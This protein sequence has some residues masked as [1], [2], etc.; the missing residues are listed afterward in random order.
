MNIEKII[1]Q[2]TFDEK[3]MLLT[4]GEG[5]MLTEACERLG[6]KP[7]KLA[8]GPHGI[9]AEKEKNCTHFP[10][11]CS[12]AA[13]WSKEA[14]NKMGDALGAECIKNGI[15]MLLGPG[16]NIKRTPLC[17]RNFEYLSEDPVLAGELGAEYIKGL[18]S[19]NVA[20]CPKHYALNNQE[21]YRQTINVEAD[22][23]TMREIYLK[24]FEIAVKKGKPE[25]IMSAYNKVN[26]IWCS[27]NK[28]LLKS[29][30]RDEWNYDGLVISD[31]GSVHDASRSAAAGCDMQMGRNAKIAEQLKNGVE[32]GLVTIEEIDEAVRNTLKFLTRERESAVEYD[33]E[34]Q[35]RIA[36][37]IA[38]EG[39]VLLKNHNKT[40][41]ITSKKY[42]KIAVLGEFAKEA[43]IC[44]QG[45]AE[46]FPEDKYIDSPLEKLK[47][48]LPDCEIE[49]LETFK[50]GEYSPKMLW[51][52]S[53]ETL[54]PF[55][56]DKDLVVI[57]A[58]SMLSEDTE[59]FDRRSVKLNP[60]Y[61][62][63]I[64]IVKELGKKAVVVLQTGSAVDVSEFKENAD[65]ILEMWL[66]GEG[67]GTAI[68]ETL[69]GINNP[70]GKLPETFPN[71]L[72]SD[73]NYPGTE[74]RIEY[75]EKSDVGYRYYDKHP[76]EIEYPFGYGLSYTDFEYSNLKITDSGDSFKV[77]FKIKN[78]GDCHGS[79]VAQL[80]ISDE[81]ST[82][83]KPV[84]ELK[85]FSKIFL[86]K[87]EEKE[88]SFELLPAD[89]SYYNIMLK[90][91][92]CENGKYII[93][94][95]SS[96]QDLRLKGELFYEAQ[97]PYTMTRT[98][99]DT[100]G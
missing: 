31:W 98:G 82:V 61:S 74:M 34:E 25:A 73:L 53:W 72:R 43:L 37:D 97:M 46:V 32:S 67:G 40:L 99:A 2:M 26:S 91:W 41:P 22:E 14:A 30:L 11:L 63:F 87:G 3:A 60:N 50:K 15:S 56:E 51:P 7:K 39:I 80:Y 83:K 89:F 6:I 75:N 96:S 44:G 59:K 52:Y 57:F 28:Y 88:V 16:L 95:G 65:A 100:I 58:G 8:D 94:I 21:L 78:I 13:T 77:S 42:K 27:E 85:K 84:K 79:E 18:E 70:S 55:L 49:Y 48:L 90:D 68:A 86:R 64:N 47:E 17:G 54:A 92:V 19:R 24:P 1:S 10:N 69:C 93:H 38:S 33:R 9:R 35:H 76:D 36:A 5:K 71:C 29:I 23:R 20:A 62:F 4:A 45:S 81:L 12:L 66:A